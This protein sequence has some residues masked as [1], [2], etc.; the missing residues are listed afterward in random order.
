MYLSQLADYQRKVPQTTSAD[1]RSQPYLQVSSWNKSPRIYTPAELWWP[2]NQHHS[3]VSSALA[4][5]GQRVQPAPR[6]EDNSTAIS[7]AS[8]T[9]SPSSLGPPDHSVE[10]QTHFSPTILSSNSTTSYVKAEDDELKRSKHLRLNF[11]TEDAWPSPSTIIPAA[12]PLRATHACKKMR[13]MMGVFRLSVFARNPCDGRKNDTAVV[14]SLSGPLDE[15]PKLLVF[16]AKTMEPVVHEEEQVALLPPLPLNSEQLYQLPPE[17]TTADSTLL[18]ARPSSVSS[19][20]LPVTPISARTETFQDYEVVT[21]PVSKEPL[22]R[23]A[24]F[25]EPYSTTPTSSSMMQP[26]SPF[27]PVPVFRASSPV[28]HGSATESFTSTRSYLHL[29]KVN[30]W[31]GQG[32]ATTNVEAQVYDSHSSSSY[33]LNPWCAQSFTMPPYEGPFYGTN[34]PP[35]YEHNYFC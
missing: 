35:S 7:E 5:Q 2:Y 13:D 23:E 34:H 30:S 31:R 9:Q 26:S 25:S 12:V 27:Q 10:Q 18:V 8:S 11:Q 4:H 17:E 28:P 22:A 6:A 15:H 19:C 20:T 32:V 3:A 33:P 14:A 24:H 16:D 21:C 29:D 1:E